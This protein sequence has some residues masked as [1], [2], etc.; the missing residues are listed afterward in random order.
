MSGSGASHGQGKPAPTMTLPAPLY[1]CPPLQL[2]EDALCE[3][4]YLAEVA[5]LH[6]NTWFEGRAGGREGPGCGQGAKCKGPPCGQVAG[7]ATI[8]SVEDLGLR[9]GE[10]LGGERGLR[11]LSGVHSSPCSTQSAAL[12]PLPLSRNRPP[13]I[14]LKVDG[15]SHKLPLLCGF[16]FETLAALAPEEDAFQR[17]KEA[18]LRQVPAAACLILQLPLYVPMVTMPMHALWTAG[19]QPRRGMLCTLEPAPA[20]GPA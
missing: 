17:V 5:G 20:A 3:T 18:L 19:G 2:L 4:A 14:D 13:G 1:P 7:K 12:L 11:R 9:A 10:L 6:Y 15:F 16:I 8:K